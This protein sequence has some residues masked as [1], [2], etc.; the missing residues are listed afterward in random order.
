MYIWYSILNECL[1]APDTAC[2]ISE[3]RYR[4]LL[5]HLAGKLYHIANN[6]CRCYPNLCTFLDLWTKNLALPA[7]Q[8][9]KQAD[10]NSNCSATSKVAFCT[11]P[12]TSGAGWGDHPNFEM[13]YLTQSWA[14]LLR[15][16]TVRKVL[17]STFQ[18]TN[19]ERF[20]RSDNDAIIKMDIFFPSSAKTWAAIHNDNHITPN[21]VR[22]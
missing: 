5:S 4:G 14:V 8:F 10:K 15:K 16:Y 7:Y 19:N 21:F 9:V 6:S 11:F 1:R 17:M 20:T 18:R 22:Q 2:W 12:A 3:K 13:V